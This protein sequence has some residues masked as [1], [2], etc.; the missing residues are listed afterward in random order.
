MYVVVKDLQ[1][2]M[3][4]VNEVWE[5][6]SRPTRINSEGV[7]LPGE[8]VELQFD[9]YPRVRPGEHSESFELLKFE[10]EAI[11]GSEFEI[12]FKVEK[13]EQD[14]VLITSPEFG[15][16]NMRDCRRFSCNQIDIVNDG[17]VYPVVEYHESCW[18]K[19]KFEVDKE[20]WFYCP[21]AQEL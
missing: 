14:I 5:S 21:Y 2:S 17:E 16:I 9:L 13:G 10:G 1:D 19:I 8:T 12:D 15:F 18:Y 6:F 20:G 11:N 3:F 7:V 4:S